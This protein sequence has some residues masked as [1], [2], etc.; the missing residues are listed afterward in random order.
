[1]INLRRQ[2]RARKIFRT[3]G[4]AGFTAFS[5]CV[6][7]SVLFRKCVTYIVG[8]NSMFNSMFDELKDVKKVFERNNRFQESY[9]VQYLNIEIFKEKLS[10]SKLSRLLQR[11]AF[12][13]YFLWP[14]LKIFYFHVATHVTFPWS[15]ISIISLHINCFFSQSG[16]LLSILIVILI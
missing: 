16:Y 5:F 1:M 14:W 15:F 9:N 7:N 11:V 10:W 6:W 8:C 3:Q 13:C 4:F 12:S 2:F